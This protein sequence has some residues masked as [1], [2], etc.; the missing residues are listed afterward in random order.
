MQDDKTGLTEKYLVLKLHGDDEEDEADCEFTD[1]TGDRYPAVT[2]GWY[3]QTWCF[4]L[5][6]WK[7]DAYGE[8][9][10]RAMEMYAESIAPKNPT[11][12]KDIHEKLKEIGKKLHP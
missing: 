5:S 3:K 4:V 2:E 9:S 1:L 10:R 7:D 6:P 12:A 11:L 8:A